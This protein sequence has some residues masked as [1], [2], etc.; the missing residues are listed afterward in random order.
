MKLIHHMSRTI[1]DFRNFFSTDKEKTTFY[2]NQ[3][4]KQTVDL[5]KGSFKDGQIDI[6]IDCDGNP[7]ITGF[8]NEY[9]QVLISILHNARD[10][11]SER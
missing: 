9:S 2:I 10:A 8:P 3:V 11:V 4:I 5:V 1:D 6:T 7:S